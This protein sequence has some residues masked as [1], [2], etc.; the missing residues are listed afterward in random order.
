MT[1]VE[2]KKA[3]AP[4]SEYA[5]KARKDPVIV[6]RNG[7]PFAA[8]VSIRNVDE[9]TLALGTNR[10]FLK[11]IKRSKARVKKEGAVPAAEL[12]RRLGLDR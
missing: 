6:L 10:K 3:T 9:E 11:I 4:L 7:K 8:V 2:L 1:R 12:R 5:E